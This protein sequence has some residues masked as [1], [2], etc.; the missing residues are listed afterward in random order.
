MTNLGENIFSPAKT[1]YLYM[2]QKRWHEA[3]V[4]SM[5]T[6]IKL[7]IIE[8]YLEPCNE[9][10]TRLFAKYSICQTNNKRIDSWR[11][12]VKKDSIE[13]SIIIL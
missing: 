7:D 2:L 10:I 6:F 5:Q 13:E 4:N 12:K 9:N 1:S 11:Q 3:K 8:A